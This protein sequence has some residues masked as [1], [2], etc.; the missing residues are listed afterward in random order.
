MANSKLSWLKEFSR[1]EII[2]WIEENCYRRFPK[3]TELIYIKS[4]YIRR[5]RF[6]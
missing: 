5:N 2:Q 4:I 6:Y 1:D 3:K